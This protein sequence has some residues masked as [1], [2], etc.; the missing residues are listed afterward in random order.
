MRQCRPARLAQC[1]AR[2]DGGNRQRRGLRARRAAIRR[3]RQH[4]RPHGGARDSVACIDAP[5]RERALADFYTRYAADALVIDKWFSLQAMIPQPDTLDQCP[6]AHRPP[7]LLLRQSQPRARAD[8]RLRQP[9]RPSSTAPTAPATTSSPTMCWR[10]TRKI[11]RSR[12][13]SPPPS[14]PGARWKPA[15]ARWR[16]AALKR[17]KAAPSRC[18]AT[19]PI[20]SSGRWP[21]LEI[22]D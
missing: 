18:R 11:R 15:A 4:D 2:S 1:R 9:T 20:S 3:R 6:R 12:R 7:G 16:E 8:R 21:R 19:L 17:I 10:S 13:V 5:E 22:A 14:A